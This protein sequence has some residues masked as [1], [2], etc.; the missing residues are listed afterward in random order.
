MVL[1]ED[2]KLPSPL[3]LAVDLEERVP[4]DT[5]LLSDV[6]LGISTPASTTILLATSLE[7][8]GLRVPARGFFLVSGRADPAAGA[9]AA[10]GG[11]IG[12]VALAEGGDE[13]LLPLVADALSPE[14]DEER[15]D[16]VDL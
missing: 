12:L 4:L 3:D 6:A 13:R 8:P 5:R 9:R 14:E 15:P 1:C 16:K 11:E 2:K 7:G 10:A